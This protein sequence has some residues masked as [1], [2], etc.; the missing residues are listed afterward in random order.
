MEDEM[1]TRRMLAALAFVC[2][3]LPSFH[4]QAA[5]LQPLVELTAIQGITF[6]F[7]RDKISMVRLGIPLEG[8]PSLGPGPNPDPIHPGS[9]ATQIY[10]VFTGPF[11]VS[12]PPERVLQKF[13]IKEKFAKFTSTTGQEIWIRVTAVGWLSAQAVDSVPT[14]KTYL[15][16]AGAA[17]A[18]SVVEGLQTVRQTIDDIRAKQD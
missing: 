2:M 16:V 10:G 4:A 15:V 8:K 14:A 5:K 3:L 7:D 9:P 11:Y 6:I 18:V 12:D 1:R 13:G 17:D